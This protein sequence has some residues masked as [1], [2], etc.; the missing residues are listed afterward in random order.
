MIQKYVSVGFYTLTL[1]PKLY[2]KM[3]NSYMDSM[4]RK[5]PQNPA[6]PLN[7]IGDQI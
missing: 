3:I 1:G 5:C 4:K 7:F 6:N 2:N